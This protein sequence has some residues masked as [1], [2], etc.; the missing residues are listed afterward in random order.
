M[1]GRPEFLGV[2]G[3]ESGPAVQTSQAAAFEVDNYNEGDLL[4]GSAYPLSLDPSITIQHIV[5]TENPGGK[6]ADLVTASG[7]T[8]NG[9][10]LG[11]GF[12]SLTGLQIDSITINDADG[13]GGTTSAMV[14]GE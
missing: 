6:T 10:P 2:V 5:F 1:P 14:V 8:I 12:L 11:S 4:T 3:G 7:S 13:S 9:V